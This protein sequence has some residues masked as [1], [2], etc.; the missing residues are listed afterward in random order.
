[1]TF[2]EWTKQRDR[3][4]IAIFG[5]SAD[6]LPD[7]T[8]YDYYESQLSPAEAIECAI[9]DMWSYEYPEMSDVWYSSNISEAV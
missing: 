6:D 3:L 1:M 4:C 2:E 5:L 8:W 7:C 9:E